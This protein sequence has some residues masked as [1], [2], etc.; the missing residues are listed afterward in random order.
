MRAW[1]LNKETRLIVWTSEDPQSYCWTIVQ[2]PG[3]DKQICT[4]IGLV[5][6]TLLAFKGNACGFQCDVQGDG[7]CHVHIQYR[8]FDDSDN[9]DV[10][11]V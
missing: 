9:V 5:P 1:P 2:N 6:E 10:G 8:P 4:A 3:T 7:S 11:G